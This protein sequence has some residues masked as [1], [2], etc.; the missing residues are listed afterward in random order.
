MDMPRMH[1][2]ALDTHCRFCEGGYIDQHGQEKQAWRVPTAIPELIEMIEQVPRPRKLV[3]EEGPLADWLARNLG[4]HVDELVVSEPR[5]NALIAKEGEKDDPIDWRKLAQLYRG[6]Y[7]RAVHHP[8]ELERSLFKQQVQLYHDRVRQRV[9][10]ALK[11][12]WRLRRLGVRVKEKDL[13]AAA[14]AR[15]ELLNRLTGE[16]TATTTTTTTATT[17]TTMLRQDVELMLQGYDVV[18]QQ[19]K[20]LRS[21]LIEHAR[22]EPMIRSFCDLP[23]FGVVRA[24]TLFAIVDTPFRFRTRQK[25]WKY[26]GIGLERRRSGD[27]P[28]RL[29]VPLRCNRLL[30][31]VILGA[32]HHIARLGPVVRCNRLLKSVILGAAKSAIASGAGNNVFADQYE[33]WLDEGITPRSA[34]R[35]VARSQAT[36]IWGMWKSGSVFD[37][38]MIGQ[39]PQACVS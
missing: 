24:A 14:P 13:A 20:K 17:T 27:G 10:E 2:V 18:C 1:F 31:S 29:R 25:L 19:V 12:I 5:R 6:G 7:V 38:R 32:D 22:K 28:V 11:I 35:N 39:G 15:Q 4:E 21:R 30:K 37:E 16:T 23:G 34:R 26:M 33:R 9:R 8:Q 36:T 3:F